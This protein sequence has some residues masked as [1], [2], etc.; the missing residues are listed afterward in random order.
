M[1]QG[2]KS[3]LWLNEHVSIGKARAFSNPSHTGGDGT[4][5]D[6]GNDFQGQPQNDVVPEARAAS[7]PALPS[8]HPALLI[9]RLHPRA[10]KR[11]T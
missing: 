6:L 11:G 5:K 3:R 7:R 9:A 10:T 1:N 2:E 8:T 4:G